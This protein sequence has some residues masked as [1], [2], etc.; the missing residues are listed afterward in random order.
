LAGSDDALAGGTAE[1]GSVLGVDA[2]AAVRSGEP[3][4][5]SAAATPESV[6]P[7]LKNTRRPICVPVGKAVT[8]TIKGSVSVPSLNSRDTSKVDFMTTS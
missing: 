1:D 7:A 4:P 5:A 8:G 2:V 3:Q 6:M